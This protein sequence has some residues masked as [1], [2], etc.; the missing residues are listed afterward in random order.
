M[1]GLWKHGPPI[2]SAMDTISYLAITVA[3]ISTA[4]LFAIA[5]AA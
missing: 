2:I 5:I 4:M 1:G 3:V